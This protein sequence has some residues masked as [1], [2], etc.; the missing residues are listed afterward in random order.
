VVIT[1]LVNAERA[2]N[3]AEYAGDDTARF[4][5]YTQREVRL[6]LY[7]QPNQQYDAP[8]DNLGAVAAGLNIEP[9]EPINLEPHPSPPYKPTKI[10]PSSMSY[11]WS[12]QF[13]NTNPN[14]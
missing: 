4:M 6:R 8:T 10:L 5:A 3:H 12:S 2:A 13:F 7:N 1:R 9:A 11:L 14:L